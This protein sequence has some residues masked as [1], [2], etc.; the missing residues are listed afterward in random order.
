MLVARYGAYARPAID[1]YSTKDEEVQASVFRY[2]LESYLS[3]RF[4]KGL[5]ARLQ[6]YKCLV[7]AL[8]IGDGNVF[9]YVAKSIEV[10][11]KAHNYGWAYPDAVMLLAEYY[12]KLQKKNTALWAAW[13]EDMIPTATKI[14]AKH[15]SLSSVRHLRRIAEALGIDLDSGRP[16]RPAKKKALPI[17][18]LPKKALP[19]TTLPKK[20][21]PKKA[22]RAK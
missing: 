13:G 12:P 8:R 7:E 20:A 14:L 21:P 1:T 15:G 11:T 17:K 4:V 6:L 16:G 2:V 19:K 3:D 18:T 9:R 5:D 22:T 10:I